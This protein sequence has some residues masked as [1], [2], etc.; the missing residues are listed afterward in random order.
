MFA[1]LEASPER[2]GDDDDDEDA[3]AGLF[4]PQLALVA[5]AWRGSPRLFSPAHAPASGKKSVVVSSSLWRVARPKFMGPTMRDGRSSREPM[6][7]RASFFAPAA[8]EGLT[9]SL[10]LSQ[11]DIGDE[12]GPRRLFLSLRAKKKRGLLGIMALRTCGS[13]SSEHA[14]D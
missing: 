11:L 10:S 7:T 13:L 6:F 2:D 9:L 8:A 3:L 14:S 5:A 12:E 1:L 4:P